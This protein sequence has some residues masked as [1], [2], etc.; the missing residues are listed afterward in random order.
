LRYELQHDCGTSYSTIAAS[1]AAK[2]QKG[3]NFPLD[4]SSSPVF[5]RKYRFFS[6]IPRD[7]GCHPK[8]SCII[9][10]FFPQLREIHLNSCTIAGFLSANENHIS[11]P[12]SNQPQAEL[13]AV[14]STRLRFHYFRLNRSSPPRPILLTGFA[15][16][17]RP[18]SLPA[19][20]DRDGVR[21]SGSSPDRAERLRQQH[22]GPAEEN[23]P[24]DRLLQRDA[25]QSV[26]VDRTQAGTS[27]SVLMHPFYDKLIESNHTLTQ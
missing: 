5:L 1:A 3:I 15:W 11:C 24:I 20:P 7:R 2:L 23:R 25:G 13:S 16:S 19:E 9:A 14:P 10:G 4:P 26:Q 18:S 27:C 6:V 22:I 17:T 21:P 8:I 12:Q